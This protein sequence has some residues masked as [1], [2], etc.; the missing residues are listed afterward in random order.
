[1]KHT[2]KLLIG[3]TLLALVA[4]CS[5][6]AARIAIDV[7]AAEAAVAKADKLEAGGSFDFGKDDGAKILADKLTPQGPSAPRQTTRSKPRT[8]P[9]SAV[10]K[11]DISL[12]FDIVDGSLPRVPVKEDPK[13]K[14]KPRLAPGEPP[15]VRVVIDLDPPS[16]QSLPVGL[17]ARVPSPDV[18][19]PQPVPTL[20]RPVSE[21]VPLDDPTAQFSTE[22]I[23]ATAPPERANPAP[24][25]FVNLPDP[26]EHRYVSR[27]QALPPEDTLP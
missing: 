16:R 7:A 6:R 14:P 9:P 2:N 18:N 1:M 17:L 15:L 21:R 8:L 13:Y 19:K 25:W 22:A 26:F 4:G 27:M 23:L 12:P 10:D 24:V 20:S 3:L 5:K 11:T